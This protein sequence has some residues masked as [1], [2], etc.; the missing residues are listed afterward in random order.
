MKAGFTLTLRNQPL[1]QSPGSLAVP[2]K[3]SCREYFSLS[4]GSRFMLPS[5]SPVFSVLA[6]STCLDP[7]LLVPSLYLPISS[8]P[9]GFTCPFP[10]LLVPLLHLPSIPALSFSVLSL[11][12]GSPVPRYLSPLQ[13]PVFLLVL[14]APV[15]VSSPPCSSPSN[16]CPESICFVVLKKPIVIC[17]GVLG[18]VFALFQVHTTRLSKLFRL[19]YSSLYTTGSLVIGSL[20]SRCGFHTT[21]LIGDSGFHTT[22]SIT[23]WNRRRAS[24]V[25]RLL[26]KH[27][28]A[29]KPANLAPTSHRAKIRAK[30]V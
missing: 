11:P 14:P 1:S 27:R 22:P 30:I 15:P 6:G 18:V 5:S 8:V 10:S 16:T 29:P 21:R 25:S 2:P 17:H 13:S 3:Y 24:L 7:S 26:S 28:V 9:A 4:P 19:L 12:P 23:N 20:S